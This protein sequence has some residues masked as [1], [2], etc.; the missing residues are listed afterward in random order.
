MQMSDMRQAREFAQRYGVKCLTFGPPGSGKTPI[1]NTAPRPMLLASEPGL[2]SMRKS[3]VP[4]YQALTWKRI[5][6]FFDW[7][8]KSNERKNFDTV[9]IDSA[10]QIAEIYLRDNPDRISHGLQLYGKMAEAVFDRLHKLYIME[11]LHTYI[12]CKQTVEKTDV[13]ASLK[14]YFPG[15]D[16]NVKVPHLY[17]E[18]LHLD[19]Q[20]IPGVG[21]HKAFHCHSGIG[22]SCRDR[23][24]NLAEFEPPDLSAL[25]AK[26]MSD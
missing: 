11:G 1:T 7:L 20:A 23:T 5:V 15:N 24:G 9:A 10:S 14:P 2:L 25:F 6:E 13:G 3:T 4:T 18:I 16:L 17:D 19:M 8:E 21:T 22:V 12:I 26:C